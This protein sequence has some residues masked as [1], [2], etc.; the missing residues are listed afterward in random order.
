MK[1]LL[2]ACVS[3]GLL[4]SSVTAGEND[5]IQVV[6]FKDLETTVKKLP[7]A[8]NL[9]VNGNFGGNINTDEIWAGYSNFCITGPGTEGAVAVYCK[10]K[11]KVAKFLNKAD[12]TKSYTFVGHIE[13]IAG[14]LDKCMVVTEIKGYT[15][16]SKSKTDA[17][18]HATTSSHKE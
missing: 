15:D 2:T 7:V 10:S 13:K 14:N 18:T 4:V 3:I 16:N 6:K 11:S 17:T 8:S 12:A 9:E 1:I 5:K